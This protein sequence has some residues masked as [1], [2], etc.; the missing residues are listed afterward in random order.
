MS[1]KKCRSSSDVSITDSTLT[2][3]LM[4]QYR[5]HSSI[6]LCWKHKALLVWKNSYDTLE[7]ELLVPLLRERLRRT[8]NKRMRGKTRRRK[9]IKRQ[10]ML[11]PAPSPCAAGSWGRDKESSSF[12]PPSPPPLGLT[13]SEGSRRSDRPTARPRRWAADSFGRGE[14]RREGVVLERR[15]FRLPPR[16]LPMPSPLSR[17]RTLRLRGMSVLQ[18]G[19][20]K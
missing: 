7:I 16:P 20:S 17:P 2:T 8:T 10:V 3:S 6:Q 19:F 12:P 11:S 5:E 4:R 18:G 14:R 1:I 9:K 15:S 13:S